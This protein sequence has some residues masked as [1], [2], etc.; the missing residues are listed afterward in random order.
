M[1]IRSFIV[2]VIHKTMETIS[3]GKSLDQVWNSYK[4]TVSE[5]KDVT[6]HEKHT[7]SLFLQKIPLTKAKD[8]LK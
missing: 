8:K 6:A 1:P 7:H 3:R 4:W 2:G 5:H